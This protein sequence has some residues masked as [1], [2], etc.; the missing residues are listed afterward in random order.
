MREFCLIFRDLIWHTQ[1]FYS[2]PIGIL[3]EEGNL[4][5]IRKAMR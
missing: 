2:I 1:L 3:M 5:I 4:T